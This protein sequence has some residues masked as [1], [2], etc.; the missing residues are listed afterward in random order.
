MTTFQFTFKSYTVQNLQN[1][2]KDVQALF[3]EK[4]MRSVHLP[5]QMKKLTV[6]SSP[7]VHKKSREQFEMRTHQVILSIQDLK[8]DAKTLGRMLELIQTFKLIGVQFKLK[9]SEATKLC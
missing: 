5:T 8:Y 9:M 1:A 2:V 6:L 7:H 4:Q 3:D